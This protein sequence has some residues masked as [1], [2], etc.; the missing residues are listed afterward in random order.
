MSTNKHAAPTPAPIAIVQKNQREELRFS[1]D[2]FKGHRFVSLRI[3][4]PGRD[5]LM[6][7]TK[8]GVTFRPELIAEIRKGLDATAAYVNRMADNGQEGA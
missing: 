1:L 2:E 5:G 8:S 6:V 7:P 4:A 3:Y